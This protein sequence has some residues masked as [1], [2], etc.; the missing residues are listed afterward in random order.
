MSRFKGL[1]NLA[2]I[3]AIA[4]AVD[5]LPAGGRV[6]E[7]FSGLLLVVFVAGICLVA[8]RFYREHRIDIHRLGFHRALLYGAIALGVVM[9]AAQPRMWERPSTEFVWFVL[10]GL[11]VY[12]FLEV[13][14]YWRN[15]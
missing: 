10:V 2:I 5:F 3:L 7:V 6:A 1:R 12:S 11:V 13:F 9:V 4:A 14:R 8:A 15:N